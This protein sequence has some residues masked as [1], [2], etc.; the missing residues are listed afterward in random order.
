YAGKLIDAATLVK[1]ALAERH[2]SHG[3]LVSEFPGLAPVFPA[4]GGATRLDPVQLLE[5]LSANV[6]ALRTLLIELSQERKAE[7]LPDTA[8]DMYSPHTRELLRASSETGQ[9]VIIHNDAGLARLGIDGFYQAGE[10]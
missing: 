6:D 8:P 1:K 5:T 2:I 4:G 9:M 10:P 7:T 3:W